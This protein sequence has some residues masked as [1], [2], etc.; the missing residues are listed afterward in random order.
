MTRYVKGIRSLFRAALSAAADAAMVAYLALAVF[1]LLAVGL[2]FLHPGFAFNYLAPQV[3]VVLTAV[4]GLLSLLRPGD[5]AGRSGRQRLAFL[6][7]GFLVTV[8]VLAVAWYYFSPVPALRVK[9][10]ALSAITVAFL[11]IF[12]AEPRRRPSGER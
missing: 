2:D 4:C 5:R 8:S 11:F 3:L 12:A 7:V 10:T 6:A 9:L 1:I